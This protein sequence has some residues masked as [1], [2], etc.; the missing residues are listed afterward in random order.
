MTC[1]CS[2]SLYLP[3]RRT[4]HLWGS[5]AQWQRD[6]ISTKVPVSQPAHYSWLLILATFR[7][8]KSE[9]SH[10]WHCIYSRLSL[11]RLHV[12]CTQGCYG[13][14]TLAIGTYTTYGFV[15][16]AC[17]TYS[18]FI[19]IQTSTDDDLGVSFQHRR[20]HHQGLCTVY[21]HRQSRHNYV[22]L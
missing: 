17:K 15:Y 5:A 12:H 21:I 18:H 4:W 14:Y 8:R 20:H 13:T 2:S 10:T 3:G 16:I 7:V 11:L 9:W 22:L 19:E 1:L 6:L